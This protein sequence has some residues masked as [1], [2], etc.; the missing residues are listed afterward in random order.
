MYHD[1]LEDNS[2]Q[3]RPSTVSPDRPPQLKILCGF[4]CGLGCDE[5]G[6]DD[7]DGGGSDSGTFSSES[8]RVEEQSID[9]NRQSEGFEGRGADSTESQIFVEE[10]DL[11]RS[12]HLSDGTSQSF[13][14]HDDTTSSLSVEPPASGDQSSVTSSH[15]SCGIISVGPGILDW[16]EMVSEATVGYFLGSP[17]PT[18]N[19]FLGSPLRLSPQY[20]HCRGKAASHLI[21]KDELTLPEVGGTWR[22]YMSQENP[23][24]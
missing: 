7:G 13:I 22:T 6:E 4:R 18:V 17:T 15:I 8:T 16:R 9:S 10:P 1:E 5:P 11:D 20:E 3:P 12:Q 14:D 19:Y 21:V 23:A 24:F 2:N